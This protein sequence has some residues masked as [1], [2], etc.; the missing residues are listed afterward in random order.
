[1]NMSTM[2]RIRNVPAS[3]PTAG[4]PRRSMRTVIVAAALLCAAGAARGEVALQDEG[5]LVFRRICNIQ[6][7]R[8]A[9][10]AAL[11]RAMVDLVGSRYPGAEMSVTTGRWM[12]A[13]QSIEHPVDQILFSERHPDP[14]MRRDFTEILMGDEEF[15][16]LQREMFGVIDFN[17]CTET[18]FRERP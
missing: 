1:M 7:G 17:S 14:G 8:D 10:A 15:R 16:G 6:P 13:F 18:R 5:P 3:A 11:A 4:G 9:A 2:I 12:T